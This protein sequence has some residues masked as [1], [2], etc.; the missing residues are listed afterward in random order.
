MHIRPTMYRFL[1]ESDSIGIAAP[2]SHFDPIRFEAGL[3][4]LRQMGFDVRLPEGLFAKEGFL[5][6]SDQHRAEIFNFLMAAGDVKAI[7]AARG[8]YG[9]QRIL[10]LIDYHL[11][12][13]DHKLIIGFSDLTVV[14]WAVWSRL[15]L[16]TIHG[17]TITTLAQSGENEKLALKR[18]ILGKAEFTLPATQGLP[19]RPGKVCA[20]LV[21]GNLT[22]LCHLVGTDFSPRF[23]G[24]ILILE[25]CGEKA[26]RIDR[27]VYQM[28]QAGCFDKIMGIA[29]GRFSGCDDLQSVNRI[30]MSLAEAQDV[31]LLAGLPLGHDGPNY[32]FVHGAFAELDTENGKLSQVISNVA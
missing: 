28:Q 23:E 18:L 11:L 32:P 15:K 24:C 10:D 27:M 20:P 21:G 1:K 4:T 25:D 2:A 29:L 19:R 7:I 31:P 30:F 17:P 6:G 13:R 8:G 16:A 3:D 9:S 14:L 22:S 12:A 26:Y 5:A